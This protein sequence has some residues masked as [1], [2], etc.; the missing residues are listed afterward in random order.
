MNPGQWL[1]QGW[2]EGDRWGDF[3]PWEVSGNVILVGAGELLASRGSRPGELRNILHCTGR[4]HKEESPSP[5][6]Q[7]CRDGDT[8]V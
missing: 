8:L 4:P 6:C 5:Q 2:G 7:R 3:A 1:S